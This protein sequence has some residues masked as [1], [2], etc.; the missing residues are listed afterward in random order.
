MGRL[1]PYNVDDN[2]NAKT[3][4]SGYYKFGVA[5]LIGGGYG[6]SGTCII[7]VYEDYSY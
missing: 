1:I 5:T 2:G 7:I 6:T 3:V 4:L